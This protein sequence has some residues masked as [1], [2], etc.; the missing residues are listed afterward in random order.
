M[1][2][3]F[4]FNKINKIYKINKY[5]VLLIYYKIKLFNK[6]LIKIKFLVLRLIMI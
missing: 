4:K 6:K 3:K 1:K 2:I 5:P